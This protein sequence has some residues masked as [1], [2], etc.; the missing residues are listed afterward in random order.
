MITKTE[1][2]P[3]TVGEKRGFAFSVFYNNSKCANF[4]S[5]L[6]KTELGARRKLNKFLKTGEFSLYG[7]AE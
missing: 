2:G 3:A 7:N 6:Y 5:A 4:L 1:I